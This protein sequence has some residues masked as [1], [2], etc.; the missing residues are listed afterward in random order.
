MTGCGSPL[1]NTGPT[2]HWVGTEM[3]VG[4]IVKGREINALTDS[5]SQV[6][7]ITPTFV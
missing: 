6:N 1:V 5:G 2:A 7:T 4:L 3:L